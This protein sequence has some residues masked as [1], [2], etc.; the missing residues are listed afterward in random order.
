MASLDPFILITDQGPSS[1]S[2]ILFQDMTVYSSLI[3][4]ARSS[5]S[6]LIIHGIKEKLGS[7]SN[8]PKIIERQ[9][10]DIGICITTFGG[11]LIIQNSFF[12]GVDRGCIRQSHGSFELNSAIFDNSKHYPLTMREQES[13]WV[14]LLDALETI[15]V[16]SSLF[17]E[18]KFY[19]KFGGV[20]K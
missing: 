2:S 18:N 17:I 16:Q 5:F 19:S 10:Q 4:S 13:G 6:E 1:F 9:Y 12:S 20:P 7:S 15:N 14:S 11:L 8:Y 3:Y